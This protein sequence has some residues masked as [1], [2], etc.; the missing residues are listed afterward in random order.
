[1]LVRGLSFPHSNMSAF[2][3]YWTY[4]AKTDAS[5]NYSVSALPAGRYEVIVYD[6]TSRIHR[7]DVNLTTENG[8]IT[9]NVGIP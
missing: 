4:Q 7:T 9:A 8:V 3:S 1:V 2:S 5:G 6:D